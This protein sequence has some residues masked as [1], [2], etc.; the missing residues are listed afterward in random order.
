[1]NI[2]NKVQFVGWVK[3]PSKF[4][5]SSKLLI[6][7]SLYEGLPNTLIDSVNF[8]LP[9]ISSDCSGAKDILLNRSNLYYPV[10]DYK[11]LSKK[12]ENRIFNYKKTLTENIILKRNLN[13]F[14]ISKQVNKY[15]KYC[16]TI[17]NH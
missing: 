5:L 10:N 14:I 1:M 7:P 3:N 16:N 13:K 8:N 6:F 15:I 4:Y 11:L 17:L 9:C 12:M 2:L